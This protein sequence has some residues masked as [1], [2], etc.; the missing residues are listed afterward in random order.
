LWSESL[1]GDALTG[2]TIPIRGRNLVD[3]TR[4]CLETFGSLGFGSEPRVSGPFS[5]LEGRSGFD[6]I[7]GTEQKE[8]FPLPIISVHSFRLDPGPCVALHISHK[9]RIRKMR[10]AGRDF[11]IFV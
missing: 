9:K 11:Y 7:H 6:S 3:S 8:P 4:G 5:A 2:R 1:P 10:N